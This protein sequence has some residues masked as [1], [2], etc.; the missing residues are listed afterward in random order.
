MIPAELYDATAAYLIAESGAT[1]EAHLYPGGH[2]FTE[3]GVA[4]LSAWLGS[5][6]TGTSRV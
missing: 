4:D 1:L 5:L 2:G 3:Q 6:A